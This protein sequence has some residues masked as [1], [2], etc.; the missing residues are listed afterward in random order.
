M[1]EIQY[2]TMYRGLY[3]L[4][5][6]VTPLRTDCGKICGRACCHGDSQ[7][8]MFLFPHEETALN[9]ISAETGTIAVCE[10]ECD[11]TLRPLSCR[12]FPLFPAVDKSGNI[13]PVADLRGLGICPLV[14]QADNVA[15]DRRFIRHITVAGRILA[16]DDECRAFLEKITKEIEEIREIRSMS[17]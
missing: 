8:G 13:I 3:R 10:G 6:G 5:E 7:T 11:R 9:T 15:F 14:R 1:N 12:I 17:Y 16:K 2:S 4:F